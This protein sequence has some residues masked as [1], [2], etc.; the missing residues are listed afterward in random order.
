MTCDGTLT[1]TGSE[2]EIGAAS[3]ATAAPP[4]PII[5]VAG[6]GAGSFLAGAGAW[7]AGL[8][9]TATAAVC[10][11]AG[12]IVAGARRTSYRKRD[13]GSTARQPS[14]SSPIEKPPM[15]PLS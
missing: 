6:A 10:A 8:G 5:M 1:T 2:R 12:G 15:G 3:L 13:I 4:D 11:G 14:A 7:D 9:G